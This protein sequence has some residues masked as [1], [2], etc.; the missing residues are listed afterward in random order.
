MKSKIAAAIFNSGLLV[1]VIVLLSAP[2]LM[3]QLLGTFE[4]GA[5]G[6]TTNQSA[7]QGEQPQQLA[8]GFAVYPNVS[9]FTEYAAFTEEP[10]VGDGIYQTAVT[11]T[12]FS[13]QQAAYNS[14]FTVY[15]TSNDELKLQ[16][17]GGDLSGALPHS[18]I[19]LN[20]VPD[21]EIA[22]TLVTQTAEV[23]DTILQLAQLGSDTYSML[24]VGSDVFE[25]Q[26]T[27]ATTFT[28]NEPLTRQVV[29]GEKAYLGP[30]FYDGATEPVLASSHTIT[31][32]PQQKA[33]VSLTVATSGEAE[34]ATSQAVLPLS[35]VVVE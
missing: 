10:M 22:S 18:K 27:S 16:V 25:G 9:D 32:F 3:G 19:W 20:M 23:G 1:V 4:S 29:V 6:V 17:N 15:N 35:I 26:K 28:L 33:T 30:L 12:A 31:L 14:L 11:F 7:I 34:T 5:L 21:G 8:G 13:G 2:L 24:V